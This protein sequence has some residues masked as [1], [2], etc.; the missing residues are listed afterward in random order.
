M[1]SVSS[2]TAR[3]R[4]LA[5][6]GAS[7][8]VGASCLVAAVATR[9]SA[10]GQ[11][12]LAVDGEG[13]LGRLDVLFDRES[14]PGVRWPDVAE[15]RGR[16]DGR[17]LLAQLPTSADGVHVLSGRE[18][19]S[20]PAGRPLGA[21][22]PDGAP[23]EGAGP[24]PDAVAAVL[25]ALASPDVGLDVIVLDLC[26]RVDA[27]ALFAH[28]CQDL[29]VLVGCGVPALARAGDAVRRADDLVPQGCRVWIAQRCPRTR[30]DL[31]DIVSEALGVP[32]LT[33]VGDDPDL[34]QRLSR[35]LA[36]GSGR[37]PLATAADRVLR[38]LDEQETP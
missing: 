13:S 30:G 10:R 17:A 5:I 36:P 25:S 19:G 34:D 11:S 7:G 3:P 33:I 21:R 29:A 31:G 2:A 18:P 28:Q 22:D 4:V 9:A 15:A 35:G 27:S 8:G 14:V 6:L 1:R 16:V 12:V 26:R 32:L 20:P 37:G 38:R 23:A 24:G